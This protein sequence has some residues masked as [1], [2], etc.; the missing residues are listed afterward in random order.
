MGIVASV[1]FVMFL[2]A[3]DPVCDI[4]RLRV[5]TADRKHGVPCAFEFQSDADGDAHARSEPNGKTGEDFV[6]HTY[7]PSGRYAI[8]VQCLGYKTTR[9]SVFEWK[10]NRMGCGKCVELGTITVTPSAQDQ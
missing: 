8:A 6:V 3:C 5:T 4:A 2:V 10:L 7:S 9:T 1:A